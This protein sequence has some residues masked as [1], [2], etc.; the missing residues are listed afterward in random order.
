L[1][2]ELEEDHLVQIQQA[3]EMLA[4]DE[5]LDLLAKEDPAAANLVKLRYFVGM[6]MDETAA[7]LGLPLRSAERTWTYARAWLKRQIG[8][9][10]S[11][12]GRK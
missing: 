3:D 9:Q 2:E 10:L 6:T 5:A 12:P 11:S 7:T 1:R 4:V 8:R